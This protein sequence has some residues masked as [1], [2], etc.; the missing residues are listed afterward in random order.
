MLA[1]SG[2][3]LEFAR[4]WEFAYCFGSAITTGGLTAIFLNIILPQPN[5][6]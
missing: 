5:R 2:N 3:W 6:K 4:F 1:L